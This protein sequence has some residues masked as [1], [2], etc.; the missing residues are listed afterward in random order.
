[1]KAAGVVFGVSV[2]LAGCNGGGGSDSAPQGNSTVTTAQDAAGLWTGDRQQGGKAYVANAVI[3]PDGDFAFADEN[4]AQYVG[5]LTVSGSSVSGVGSAYAPVLCDGKVVNKMWANGT[6]V[7]PVNISGVVSTKGKLNVSYS[8]TGESGAFSLSYD[9]LN[10][11]QMTTSVMS[12]NYRS[13]YGG[14]TMSVDAAGTITGADQYGYWNGRAE[15]IRSDI[16]IAKV[17]LTYTSKEATPRTAQ[18]A[19]YV[20]RGEDRVPG[21]S[22]GMMVVGESAPLDWFLMKK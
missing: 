13:E 8:I 10:S 21:D 4:C 14:L 2:L 18:Y 19:G 12:G 11:L 7:T 22:L 1:M 5:K 3:T 6:T 20:V 9:S 16:N 15:P 17:T